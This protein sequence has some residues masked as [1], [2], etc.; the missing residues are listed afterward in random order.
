M[1]VPSIVGAQTG[2]V[3]SGGT[4]APAGFSLIAEDGNLLPGLPRVQS[5]VFMAAGKTYDVM[6][7][8]P[9]GTSALPIFDRELSLSANGS[10]RDSGMLAYIG[11]NGSG[12]AA[13]A[14]A[15]S[16]NG[17]TSFTY[18]CTPGVTLSIS[19]PLKGVLGSATNAAGAVLNGTPSL[20]NAKDSLALN[21]NGTF[22]YAPDPASAVCGATFAFT[23][24]GNAALG[25][26]VTIAQC[27]AGNGCQ[28][29]APTAN[30]DAF[31]SS[32]ASSVHIGAPG[33]LAND[34]DPAGHPLTAV[35]LTAVNGGTV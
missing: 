34:S 23:L 17:T 15:P 35:G 18:Y 12:V 7:N 4:Q 1:H 10:S 28:T 16:L 30:P 6:M 22:T 14:V 19:D 3:P 20:T 13:S 21:P 9:T 11:V 2:A 29:G 26:A 5:E 25:G 31:S 32:V 33:V 27:S 8:V 24:N